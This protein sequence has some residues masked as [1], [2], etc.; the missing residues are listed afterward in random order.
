MLKIIK[1]MYKIVFIAFPIL[2]F[3]QSIKVEKNKWQLIGFNY[4]INLSKIGLNKYDTI[5]SYKDSK[6]YCYKEW[7]DV[8]DRCEV[9]DFIEG[10]QGFWFYSKYDNVLSVNKTKAKLPKIKSR[11]NL[12]TFS[13]DILADFFNN[14]NILAIWGYKD[15]K[16]YLYTPQGIQIDGIENLNEIKRGEAVWIYAKDNF[17]YV[18]VGDDKS[19][20]VNGNFIKVIKNSSDDIEDIWDISFKID[21]KDVNNFN[22]GIKF[23]K[24]ENDG[25]DDIGEFVYKNLSIKNK[26]LSSPTLISI[27]G[28]G[29]SGEGSTYYDS[30]YNPNNI[31]KNSIKLSGDILTLKLG[32]IM[33]KQSIVDEPTFKVKAP[34]KIVITSNI[35]LIKNSKN[36]NIDI[37]NPNKYDFSNSYGIEGKIEI[38]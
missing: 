20:L 32:Y 21:T 17:D 22:I 35:K 24:K 3:S 5:W 7:D 26:I 8:S 18:S 15:N 31:L 23:R 30:S 12:V 34:Y 16:W 1:H 10:G 36:I 4:D 37:I 2:L 6:W 33:K 9:K 29:D 14:S 38:K 11:W 25:S 27:K 13:E 28:T 19:P